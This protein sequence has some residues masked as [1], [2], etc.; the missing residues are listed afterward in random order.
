LWAAA[1]PSVDEVLQ[2]LK[3]I[4]EQRGLSIERLLR[5]HDS[6]GDDKL[7][8]SEFQK[9][10]QSLSI[11]I[12]QETAAEVFKRLDRD[13]DKQLSLRALFGFDSGGGRSE[14]PSI[15]FLGFSANVCL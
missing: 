12:D 13:G 2:V 3:A 6:S 8:F 9:L 14:V 11:D 5:Q 4:K 15:L 10:L 1:R 7:A